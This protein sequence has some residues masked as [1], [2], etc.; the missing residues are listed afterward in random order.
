M[1]SHV[2]HPTLTA[3]LV[4]MLDALP[5]DQSDGLASTRSEYGIPYRTYRIVGRDPDLLIGWLRGALLR[6]IDAGAAQIVWRTQPTMTTYETGRKFGRGLVVRF[7]V[8]PDVA[9]ASLPPSHEG[10]PAISIGPP[11]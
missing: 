8:M 2:P 10:G 7:H 5:L 9:N 11:V 3:D 1:A 4:T 6:A